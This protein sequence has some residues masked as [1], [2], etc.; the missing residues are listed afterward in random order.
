VAKAHHFDPDRGSLTTFV[1]RVVCSGVCEILRHRRR[2]RRAPPFRALS[3]EST[4]VEIDGP[5]T[6]ICRAISKEDLHRRLG[7]IA[8][9]DVDRHEDAV[10][11]DQAIGSMSPGLRSL[12]QR[13][14]NHSAHSA[15][16][17][18][19]T[20][21]RQVRNAICLIRKHLERAGF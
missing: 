9:D 16:R 17:S 19:N 4:V 1:E 13:L 18:L 3:L 14:T 12:C 7:T 6:P 20:S 21:R 10:T 15:T 2:Q 8:T 11:L 5:P